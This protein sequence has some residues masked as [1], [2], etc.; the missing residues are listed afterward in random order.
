MKTAGLQPEFSFR[1][2]HEHGAMFAAREPDPED[3]ESYLLPFR[4]LLLQKEPASLGRINNILAQG[5]TNDELRSWLDESRQQWKRALQYGGMRL[6]IRGK[7]ITPEYA[8]DL[9]INGYYFHTTQKLE[10]LKNFTG[11]F[12]D[13]LVRNR[14]LNN[15]YDATM[16]ALNLRNITMIAVREGHCDFARIKPNLQ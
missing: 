7:E 15:V 5:L 16:Y 8:T 6:V 10:E 9:W 14:F 4:Q 11:P 12:E 13:I 1:F 2:H 3:L